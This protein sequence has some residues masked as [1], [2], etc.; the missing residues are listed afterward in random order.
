MGCRR[1]A[2]RSHEP[3]GP[4]GAQRSTYASDFRPRSRCQARWRRPGRWPGLT[5]R[6]GVDDL[7]VAA[8]ERAQQR[9]R[10]RRRVRRAGNPA[11]RA[12]DPP[13]EGLN[14]RCGPPGRSVRSARTTARSPPPRASAAGGSRAPAPTVLTG[15]HRA[16]P[17]D[18]QEELLDRR[19]LPRHQAVGG[20]EHD[21]AGG[22][23]VV[24]QAQTA[25]Y[26]VSVSAWVIVSRLRP[27]ASWRSTWVKA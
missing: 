11:G 19:L 2:S 17:A 25:E 12:E 4:V 6:G 9:D 22:V 18:E 26:G 3:V 13:I 23:A 5:V 8:E 14:Q 7:P 1:R 20:L 27:S 24:V 16:Q 15:H 10:V 21:R